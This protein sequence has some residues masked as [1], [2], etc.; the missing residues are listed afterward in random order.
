MGVYAVLVY[1]GL[2]VTDAIDGWL[3]RRAGLTSMLGKFLDPLAD[4]LLVMS[5]LIWLIYMERLPTLGVAAV[6]LIVGRELA[7]NALR[8]IAI[9]EGLVLAAGR[10]GKDKTAV[11]MVAILLLML[12]HDYDVR[13]FFT[14]VRASL[15]EV[16]LGL[17]YVSLV[18]AW[19]SAAEYIRQFFLAAEGQQNPP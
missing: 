12:H 3:A 17:L 7:I 6:I 18:L 14:T 10:G 19:I 5:V 13:L 15:H 16:G 4:K 1:I 8:T 11:Q 9:S 2:A